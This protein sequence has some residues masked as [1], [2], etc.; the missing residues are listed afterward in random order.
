MQ[1]ATVF[2]DLAYGTEILLY[3]SLNFENENKFDE[4][5]FK[6]SGDSLYCKDVRHKKF[7][8]LISELHLGAE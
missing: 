8:T 1:I 6:G 5:P 2:R 3:R 7:K 4:I